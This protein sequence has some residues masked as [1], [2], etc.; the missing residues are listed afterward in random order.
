M[1]S[2]K[3]CA[4]ITA[5]AGSIGLK[6]KNILPFGDSN[7][8]Q[9]TI[10]FV[11]STGLFDQII[12]STDI[13]SLLENNRLNNKVLI[14]KRPKKLATSTTTQVEVVLHIIEE[15]NHLVENIFLFQP[16]SPFRKKSEI[17]KIVD[18]L[19]SNETSTES[20]VGVSN[21]I[22]HPSDCIFLANHKQEF[23]VK[24][25]ELDQRQ[26]FKKTFFINGSIYGCSTRFLK[27]EKSFIKLDKSKLQVMSDY[28][29]IDIDDELTYLIAK[30]LITNF[31]PNDI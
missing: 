9:Y 2:I 5:R 8:T 7:L 19:N 28:S 15:L 27:H 22:N 16:T 26:D 12:L 24:R 1:K 4:I 21:P 14:H 18:V 23:V 3:N 20:V 30:N 31:N 11:L 17:K 6:N 10:D 29:S 13:E 25:S